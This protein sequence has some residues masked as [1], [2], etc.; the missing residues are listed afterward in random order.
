L[1]SSRARQSF[2]WL[3]GDSRS[4]RSG[5]Q[6]LRTH[7]DLCVAISAGGRQR[8]SRQ[9]R[10]SLWK[11][12]RLQGRGADNRDYRRV[13]TF[14][15]PRCRPKGGLAADE[16]KPEFFDSIKRG[17][18]H[19]GSCSADGPV[20]CYTHAM[21]AVGSLW[22]PP[23]VPRRGCVGP[24][25]VGSGQDPSHRICWPRAERDRK[26]ISAHA[27]MPKPL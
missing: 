11:L 17:L 19:D 23:R 12:R 27:A 5:A 15:P 10:F 13:R 14:Q 4:S 18:A 7:A 8:A 16:F 1:D 24:L 26:P 3:M 9:S 20:T 6:S 21:L 2:Q 22:N 25:W